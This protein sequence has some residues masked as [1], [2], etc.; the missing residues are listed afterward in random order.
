VRP[1]DATG[2]DASS[3][4]HRRGRKL[5]TMLPPLAQARE[6]AAAGA[7]SGGHQLHEVGRTPPGE[8]GG[9]HRCEL[10][11]ARVTRRWDGGGR[12]DS[13]RRADRRTAGGK[14]KAGRPEGG[15]AGGTSQDVRW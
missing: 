14:P 2:E 6:A 15:L 9:R 12:E 7:R 8:L 1:R 13:R 11:R 3:G 5:G 4:C 10:G